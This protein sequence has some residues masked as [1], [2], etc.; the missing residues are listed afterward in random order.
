M[1][2]IKKGQQT[3]LELFHKNDVSAP[4]T[5]DAHRNGL[6]LIIMNMMSQFQDSSFVQKTTSYVPLQW[7]HLIQHCLSLKYLTI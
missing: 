1:S 4:L 6:I 2:I 5:L 7:L 3:M